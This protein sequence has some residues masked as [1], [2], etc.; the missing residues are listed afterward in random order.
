LE[1]TRDALDSVYGSGAGADLNPYPN[2]PQRS[3]NI[4]TARFLANQE[5]IF[6]IFQ[7]QLIAKRESH[8]DIRESERIGKI[9]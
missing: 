9:F 2:A 3:A 7:L 8:L 5:H 4:V 1:A 6:H